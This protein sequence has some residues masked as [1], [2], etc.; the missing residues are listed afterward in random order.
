MN[1]LRGAGFSTFFSKSSRSAFR[2]I[3]K[4]FINNAALTR[5][6]FCF[7]QIPQN[8]TS[9]KPAARRYEGFRNTIKP[10]PSN[11]SKVHMNF[12]SNKILYSE[13]T[14]RYLS[15][16]SNQPKKISSLPTLSIS[17]Y[18]TYKADSIK[19]QELS[20]T[21]PSIVSINDPKPQVWKIQRPVSLKKKIGLYM[22]LSKDKL[23]AFV[24]L[25]A[26]A[27]Y[28][29]A[30]LASDVKTLVILTIGTGMCSASANSINQWSEVPYDAQMKRTRNRPLVRG[31]IQPISAISFAACMGVLGTTSLFYFV[32]PI[33]GILGFINIILYA[34]VYT[35]MKRISV[36]NTWVGSV[37][38]AIPPVMGWTAVTGTIDP[39]ALVL[40]GILYAWQFPHFNA[41]SYT[42][43][44]EYSVAGYR[45]MSVLDPALNSRV[46]L[47]YTISMF[48]LCALM[49]YLNIADYWFLFDSSIL[50]S[51]LL[52]RAY[53]FYKSSS[54]ATSRP[55]F[56]ASLVHLPLLLILLILH[57]NRNT[58]QPEPVD[59]SKPL[60]LN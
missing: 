22:D 5:Q 55:L 49:C 40:A 12:S 10:T 46:S 14:F 47:R 36:T 59:N 34:F 37:V 31:A 39:G 52:F 42:I 9:L 7:S 51:Y 15:S 38:G 30:P 16:I 43:R 35:P 23:T 50:N 33:T 6:Y 4:V 24:V 8:F 19:N 56:F 53:K 26:M 57:K 41:L 44:R 27:G 25:T 54:N 60:A 48:P 17:N 11:F 21:N 29:I 1:N 45:M 13:S 58:D 3:P 2:A 28:A 32:N 20:V 18:S